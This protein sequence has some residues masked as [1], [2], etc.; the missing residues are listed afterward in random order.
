MSKSEVLKEGFFAACEDFNN[1]TSSKGELCAQN[2]NYQNEQRRPSSSTI[3]INYLSDIDVCD[4]ALP[5]KQVESHDKG[6]FLYTGSHYGQLDVRKPLG[7]FRGRMHAKTA[8][9]D[10]RRGALLNSDPRKKVSHCGESRK[11]LGFFKKYGRGRVQ[12]ARIAHQIT[13]FGVNDYHYLSCI[14]IELN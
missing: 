9:D 12:A 2:V 4:A 7:S 1:F 10:R 3:I 6:R 8:G 13:D 11:I 14:Y 5:A